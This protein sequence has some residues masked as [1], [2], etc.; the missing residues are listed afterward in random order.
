MVLF[1][2]VFVVQ[3]AVTEWVYRDHQKL[4][5]RGVRVG[6]A[7]ARRWAYGVFLAMYVFLPLYLVR[8]AKAIRTT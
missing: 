1:L 4:R 7:S 8:R 2:V 6:R 5:F 3:V